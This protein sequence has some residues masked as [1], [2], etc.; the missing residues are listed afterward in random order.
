MV[1]IYAIHTTFSASKTQ[2]KNTFVLTI[3][4]CLFFICETCRFYFYSSSNLVFAPEVKC[5]FLYLSL[6]ILLKSESQHSYSV[7]HTLVYLL[8]CSVK[9]F[10]PPKNVFVTPRSDCSLCYMQL[11]L[12]LCIIRQLFIG[13]NI[14]T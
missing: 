10:V 7:I 5:F 14:E 12:L 2:E 9:T 13:T 8:Y 1:S 6:S 3:V 4:Y 11:L